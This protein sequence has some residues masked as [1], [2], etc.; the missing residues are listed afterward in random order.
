M[1]YYHHPTRVIPSATGTA[2]GTWPR[3]ME[4]TKKRNKSIGGAIGVPLGAAS[5]I[6]DAICT[7]M[8]G[9][10]TLNGPTGR[11]KHNFRRHLYQHG[12]QMEPKPYQRAL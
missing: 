3:A 11:R 12:G 8:E 1:Q 4:T 5:A 2:P 9:K 6:S 7:K 10:W